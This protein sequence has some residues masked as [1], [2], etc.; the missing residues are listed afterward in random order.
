[1]IDDRRGISHPTLS[2]WLTRKPATGRS[3]TIYRCVICVEY[4]HH[5]Y[6]L[7]TVYH[8]LFLFTF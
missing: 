5:Y 4:L 1:M 7:S 8:L 6:Y 3:Y 2:H